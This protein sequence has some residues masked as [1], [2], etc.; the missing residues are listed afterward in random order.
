MGKGFWDEEGDPESIA[1]G[2]I[3]PKDGRNKSA[4]F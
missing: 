2:A 3:G 1:V 4:G